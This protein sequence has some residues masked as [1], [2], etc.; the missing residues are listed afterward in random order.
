MPE[1]QG[2]PPT[3]ALVVVVA[4][5]AVIPFLGIPDLIEAF[6]SGRGALYLLESRLGGARASTKLLFLREVLLFIFTG[7][8]FLRLSLRARLVPRVRTVPAF[9]LCLASSLAVSF[10]LYPPIVGLSGLRQLT[11]LTMVYSL[12]FMRTEADRV[13]HLFVRSL[14]FVA[15]CEIIPALIETALLSQ[16][17]DN[18]LLGPRVFGTF[19]DPNTLGIA[20]AAITFCVLFLGRSS[21]FTTASVVAMGIVSE[22]LSGSRTGMVAVVFVLAAL[23]FS[24]L[25]HLESR[26]MLVTFAIIMILPLYYSLAILSGREGATAPM[27]DPRVEI[28]RQQTEGKGLGELLIGRGL[29]VGTSTLYALGHERTDV[30]DLMRILDSTYISLIVQIGFIGLGLFLLTFASLSARCGFAGWVLYGLMLIVGSNGNVLEYYPFNLVVAAAYGILWGK[31][32]QMK[33]AM[34]TA[35]GETC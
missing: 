31:R 6:R 34:F 11:Y 2:G 26:G 32:E 33:W 24:K 17:E 10:M 13:E 27:Q 14:V 20:F 12:Y 30:E 35:D 3:I 4:M 18:A 25:R 1:R 7:I 5:V 22:L 21:R 16:P 29:G 28:F 23:V 8:L 15:V 9:L 19:N